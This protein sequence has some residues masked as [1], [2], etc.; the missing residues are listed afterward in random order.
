MITRLVNLW[1]RLV[2]WWKKRTGW[3]DLGQPIEVTGTVVSI[4]PPDVDGDMNFDVRVDPGQERFITGFGGRLT[5]DPGAPV[6]SIHCE[7]EPWAS[8]GLRLAYA[9]LQVG[10][11]VRVMGS[12]GFDGVHL[13]DWP[14]WVQVPLALLRH[15]PD[16]NHGWFEIHP[17]K[18]IE[19]M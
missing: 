16:V 4:V 18:G 12:W 17:V 5:N 8:L 2:F 6:P 9:R 13:N 7:I 14:L 10:A 3:I 11:R 19:V 15:G 1:W